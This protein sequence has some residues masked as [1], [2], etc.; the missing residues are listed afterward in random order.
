M[1]ENRRK[2]I[3]TLVLIAMLAWGTLASKNTLYAQAA[4]AKKTVTVTC[5]QKHPAKVIE[6][7]ALPKKMKN[8]GNSKAIKEY[9]KKYGIQIKVEIMGLKGKPTKKI[10]DFYSGSLGGSG[11]LLFEFSP[12]KYKKGTVYKDSK[13]N[14]WHLGSTKLEISLPKGVKKVTY[15]ITFANSSGKRT[16]KNVTVKN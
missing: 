16:L 13:K 10:T 1:I 3:I 11:A 12:K 7:N 2:I 15:K 5:N 14:A 8:S 6:L 4:T 9:Y